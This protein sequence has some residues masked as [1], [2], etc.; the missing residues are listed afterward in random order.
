MIPSEM[1]GLAGALPRYTLGVAGDLL[2]KMDRGHV[3]GWKFARRF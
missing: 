3:F 1:G 2:V